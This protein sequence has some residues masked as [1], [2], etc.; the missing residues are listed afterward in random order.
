MDRKEYVAKL[1]ALR[2][3]LRDLDA[4]YIRSNSVIPVGTKV[5]IHYKHYGANYPTG[6]DECGIVIG[7]EIYFDEV[8]PIVAK[9]KK[10]GTAHATAKLYVSSTANVEVCD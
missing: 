7:Y 2:K 6:Y 4:E 10:D 3:Q 1:N 9:M 8:R 5:K